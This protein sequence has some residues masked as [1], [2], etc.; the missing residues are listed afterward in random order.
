MTKRKIILTFFLTSFLILVAP[1]NVH[2]S[3]YLSGNSYA[4]EAK[5]HIVAKKTVKVYKMTTG[6]YEAANH[7]HYYGTIKRGTALYRSAYLMSTGGFIVKSR[8]YYHNSRTFFI[9]PQMSSNWYTKYSPNFVIWNKSMKSLNVKRRVLKSWIYSK[10][11]G[12]RA[13]Y[14]KNYPH[15]T[16]IA[17]RHEKIENGAIYYYIHS[18]YGTAK[19]WVWRGNVKL[20]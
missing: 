16:W 1:T 2:A 12:K 9:V 18:K 3:K 7:A 13:H 17:T 8:K 15:T 6:K 5:A 19:G 10:P 20:V 4:K 11:G 14:L